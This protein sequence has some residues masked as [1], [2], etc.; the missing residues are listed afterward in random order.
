M[1]KQI[2]TAGLIAITAVS[3]GQ[4]KEIKK[5]EK[6]V[7]SGDL[8]EAITYLSQAEAILA[9]ADAS[10][11]AQFY[12]TKGNAY[13]ADAGKN[14]FDK[15]EIAAESYK[16]AL[17]LTPSG[18]YADAANIG[19]QNL[20]VALVNGAIDD[21]KAKNYSRASK[22]LY[23]SY[24]VS[25]KDTS[26]LYYAAGNAVNAQEYDNAIAYYKQLLDLG[27]TGIKKEYIATELET[28]KIVVFADKSD[29]NTN[30]LS[31][32][33]TNPTERMSES[34]KGEILKNITL[35]YISKGE[36]DKAI[37]LMEE[38]RKENPNDASLLRAEADMAYKMGDMQK[39]SV[40]MQKIIETD[41]TNPELYYN[42]GV[43]S[44]QNGDQEAAMKYYKKAIELKPDYAA[45]KIN[46]AAMILA[47]EGPLNEEMNSLGTSKADYDRYDLLKE[48]KN[49]LYKEALPYLEDA[50]V[51]RP[52]NIEIV[53]TL[54][55]IYGQ[56]GMDNKFNEM[57][58]K[59]N[60][61]EGGQ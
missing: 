38:A 23:I 25:K 35:I 37:A 21:Q 46:I 32:K 40:M 6:A 59:L 39:Y 24:T 57:K 43:G 42:L 56:L 19:T 22:K 30:M 61:M 12:V 13:L 44:S 14:D 36:N 29:R 28:N 5:A 50:M 4:K 51:L 41:P 47:K 52:N 15:L 27:Y 54:K 58:S 55:G 33:Y 48:Q 10:T 18:K 3:F 31:G 7:K 11:K 9:S 2:L 34:A 49:N 20:R 1:K 8:T 45:A 60:T 17:E 26:D 53:R 16:K